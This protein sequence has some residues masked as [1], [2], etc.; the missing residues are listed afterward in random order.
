MD[1]RWLWLIGA[2]AMTAV[3]VGLGVWR[4]V[5]GQDDAIRELAGRVGRLPW[6]KKGRLAWEL[7][8]DSRI[9]FWVRVVIPALGLYLVMPVDVIPDFIPVLGYLDDVL[10]VLVAVAALVRFTPRSVLADH[11]AALEVPPRGGGPA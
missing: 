6:R 1:A 4:L 5:R 10:L 8:R 9:P 2:A 11:V 7:V 3:L